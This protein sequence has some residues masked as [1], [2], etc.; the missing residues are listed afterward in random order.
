M[1]ENRPYGSEGGEG[2]PF[3]TPIKPG[4]IAHK[5]KEKFGT[6]PPDRN[7][8]PLVPSTE[9]RSWVRSRLIAYAKSRNQEAGP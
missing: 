7:V 1:R 8:E 2:H 5:F 3:P 4:W 9:V 6:W